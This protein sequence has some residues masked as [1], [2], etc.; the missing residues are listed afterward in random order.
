MTGK[1]AIGGQRQGDRD[2]SVD[3]NLAPLTD[4]RAVGGEDDVT[5]EHQPPGADDADFLRTLGRQ[6]NDIAILLVDRLGHAA[7]QGEPR[8]LGHVAGLA[9][10][11]DDDLGPD[12]VVHL[13]EFGTA[14]MARNVDVELAIGNGDRT[15]IAQRVHDPADGDFIARDLLGR[16]D[17]GVALDQFQFM[18][19]ECDPRQCRAGLALPAGGKDHHLVARQAH[20]F[21][22]PHRLG[23]VEQITIGLGDA[24]D[25]I[26]RSTG[27][28]HLSSGFDRHLAKRLEPRGV[29]G[30]SGDQHPPLGFLD[31]LAET[32][33]DP[34]FGPRRRVLKDVG[35]IA[36]QGED[37]L[38]ANVMHHLIAR[39][40]PEHRCLVDLPVAGVEDIAVRGLDHQAIALGDRVGQRFE[41][42]LERIEVDAP[43]ALDDV[44]LDLAD[45]PLFLKFAG[46]QRGGERRGVERHFQIG[47]EI[48]NRTD[49]I[50]MS[51]GQD[52][53]DQLLAPLLD[54]LQFGQDQVD[55]GIVGVGKG[56]AE[57]DHQPFALG[58]I[59]VDVHANLARA[60]EG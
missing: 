19:S 38:I 28:A 20:G 23:E 43:I 25:A 14:G 26:E 12:P 40:D 21:V 17:D 31:R 46:D 34:G 4:R 57:V 30:K 50:F 49:M 2:D 27:N 5:V 8:L 59:E 42:D 32:G 37:S 53:P 3:R 9:M 54:E 60:A 33:M 56:Q 18:A 10:D 29:G 11:R 44:D 41:G 15:E 48:G 52:D 16:E 13:L 55:A 7:R 24:Q 45:Q 47:G 39:W 58:A 22:E 6:A 1:A 35:R 36:H 51:M